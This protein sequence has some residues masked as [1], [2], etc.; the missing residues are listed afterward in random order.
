MQNSVLTTKLSLTS[1][2]SAPR[3][4]HTS[5]W[6]VFYSFSYGGWWGGVKD[7]EIA[8][9]ADQSVIE[10][11]CAW[12]HGSLLMSS[13]NWGHLSFTCRRSLH[14][15]LLAIIKACIL[16]S[17]TVAIDCC[18]YSVFFSMKVSHTTPWIALSV[19]WCTDA[20]RNTMEATWKHVQVHLSPYWESEVKCVI[21]IYSQGFSISWV[22]CSRIKCKALCL[23]YYYPVAPYIPF[24]SSNLIFFW[25][26]KNNYNK[27]CV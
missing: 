12:Q 21:Y 4:C 7:V 13:G 14:Q 20:H 27:I 1:H 18:G 6:V 23:V 24:I 16:P 19:F 2:S 3:Q 26:P 9:S 5:F 22:F 11:V 17:T 10:S 25:C 15:T 8:A